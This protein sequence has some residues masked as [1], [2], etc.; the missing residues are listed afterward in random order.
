ML[1]NQITNYSENQIVF[2]DLPCDVY[3]DNDD[4]TIGGRYLLK[5]IKE[6]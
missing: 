6:K 1:I 5:A 3:V 4:D 2:I